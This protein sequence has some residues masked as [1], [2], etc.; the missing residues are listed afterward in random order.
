MPTNSGIAL[1]R[2]EFLT[3]YAWEIMARQ[4]MVAPMIAPI[5]PVSKPSGKIWMA[6]PAYT[7]A[8]TEYSLEYTTEPQISG[9]GFGDN[10]YNVDVR[11]VS[12]QISFK[13]LAEADDRLG[14]YARL[15]SETAGQMSIG[16]ERQCNAEIFDSS[17]W[18]AQTTYEIGKVFAESST[19]LNA[20]HHWIDFEGADANAQGNSAIYAF[21]GD[22]SARQWSNKASPVTDQIAYAQAIVAE[23]CGHRPGILYMNEGVFERMKQNDAI[24]DLYKET[25]PGLARPDSETMN[26]LAKWMGLDEIRISTMTANSLVSRQGYKGRYVLG[27]NHA[28]LIAEPPKAM[29][30]WESTPIKSFNW[31]DYFDTNDGLRPLE[32]ST[33]GMTMHPDYLRKRYMVEGFRPTDVKVVSN[34]MGFLFLNVV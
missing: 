20:R 2:D 8:D 23:D 5:V 10:E 28:L 18:S 13:Q 17:K 7:L 27:G 29:G 25:F 21:V 24:R 1:Y 33:I 22:S 15:A 12:K 16:W 11:A 26:T 9:W 31:A 34:L 14:L 32:A 4:G 30:F 3:Q 19:E 6:D